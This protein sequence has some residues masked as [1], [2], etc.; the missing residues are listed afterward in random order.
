MQQKWLY[1]VKKDNVLPKLPVHVSVRGQLGGIIVAGASFATFKE[2]FDW[3]ENDMK[4]SEY[5][6]KTGR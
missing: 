6:E 1:F 2:A 4:V 3:I 5:Y